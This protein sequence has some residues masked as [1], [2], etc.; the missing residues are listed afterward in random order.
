MLGTDDLRS[1]S[2]L[3]VINSVNRLGVRSDKI[4]EDRLYRALD[5]LL[6]HKDELCRHLQQRYGELFGCTFD[7][8][9]YDITSTYF[10]GSAKAHPQPKRGYSR[11]GRP[12]CPQV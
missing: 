4:S 11:D 7:F 2:V 8:M 3:R 12:D 1:S 10:E 9:F 5:A 6:P